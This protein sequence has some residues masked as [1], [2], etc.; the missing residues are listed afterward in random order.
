MAEEIEIIVTATGFDKVSTGLKN[1]TEAL[2]TTAAEAKKTGDALKGSMT[3]GSNQA[4]QSLQNLSRIAQDAPFGF[5]GIANN[6]NPL[7]ESF[8]RL[9]AETGST[10]GAF[11]A[12]LG[13]LSGPAGLGLAVGVV[14]SVVQFAQ[15]GFDRWGASAK[16]AKDAVDEVKKSADEFA[17][18]IDSARAGA[19]STG[20]ALQSYV[21]I[22]KNGAL[23]LEQRNEA[24]KKA[25]EILG[26]H[27][28]LLTLTNI[29]TKAVTDEVIL[30]TKALIAQAVAQK[31][32]DDIATN[33]V[34]RTSLQKTLI[35]AVNDEIKKKNALDA[36]ELQ[37]TK[38]KN[39]AIAG[40]QRIY[41]TN[42]SLLFK[43]SKASTEYN[44][45]LDLTKTTQTA[46]TQTNKNIISSQVELTKSTF[47][48]TAAFGELG[49]KT[50]DG[51]KNKQNDKKAIE[52]LNDAYKD[53]Y[54]KV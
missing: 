27:G 35:A 41:Q 30:Y 24:L 51:T 53:C 44:T 49:T 3:A 23:P 9:R 21:D 16:K 10:G 11:K 19:L 5:I 8:G 25:N 6:I 43:L 20:L 26:K 46:L 39:A 13:S 7:V 18:S 37:I 22:A 14:T 54:Y 12:L 31:Y 40:G 34:K 32:V 38:E 4:G 2:K 29:A 50:K 45:A 28:E 33:F 48:A 1:T 15:I 17:K 36:I 52:T 47:E 42:Q